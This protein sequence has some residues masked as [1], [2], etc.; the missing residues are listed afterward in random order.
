EMS[1]L[2]ADMDISTLYVSLVPD[3]KLADEIFNTIR[4]EYD[5]T[6]E[7]VLAIS[8]HNTLLEREPVTQQ[9]I[10]LRNPYVDPLNYIQVE[11]LQR[12][13]SLPDPEGAEAQSLREVMA[14]TINGIAAGL[15]NTG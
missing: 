13:R 5:R 14:L 7:A 6:R 8:R 15:R 12:L 2:K 9:A 4:A 11:T 1:L 3:K 10:Q